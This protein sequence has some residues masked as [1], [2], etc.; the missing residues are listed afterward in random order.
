MLN[1]TSSFY[2]PKIIEFQVMG[3]DDVSSDFLN[4]CLQNRDNLQFIKERE[5]LELQSS[6][7]V[8]YFDHS[9]SIERCDKTSVEKRT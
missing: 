2:K 9:K 7:A 1:K 3:L 5:V 8:I 6:H 4:W